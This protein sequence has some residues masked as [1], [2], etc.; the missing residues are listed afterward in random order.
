MVP[1]DMQI[2]VVALYDRSVFAG[3]NVQCQKL[4]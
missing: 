3:A 1:N 2:L 4:Y